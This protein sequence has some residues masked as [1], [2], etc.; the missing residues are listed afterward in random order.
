MKK[1]S[2]PNIVEVARKKRQIYLLQKLQRSSL[3]SRELKELRAL[4]DSGASIKE[5]VM[6]DRRKAISEKTKRQFAEWLTSARSGE[7]DFAWLRQALERAGF[8][9]VNR[10]E[11]DRPLATAREMA[12]HLG[13]A[14]RTF[15]A[16]QR[17]GMPVF[18]PSLG[19]Q[20]ALYDIVEVFRWRDEREQARR[21]LAEDEIMSGRED[22]WA[23]EYRM[24]R[25]RQIRRKNDIEEGKLRDAAEMEA[26]LA[27]VVR[28]FREEIEAIERAHGPKVG[29]AVRS[30]IDHVEE[31]FARL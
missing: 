27:E 4:E 5:A 1:R 14:V 22:K 8:A 23:R 10:S 3:S 15:R 20:A 19:N 7:P 18:R 2:N 13:V 25:V 26:A 29:S 28:L 17:E 31:G 6:T 12:K 21:E 9:Q 11:A 24:E 16:W 30:A